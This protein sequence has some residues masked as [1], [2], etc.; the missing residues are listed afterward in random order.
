MWEI[1][2]F[3]EWAEISSLLTDSTETGKESPSQLMYKY[4]K[5]ND[6]MRCA[7]VFFQDHLLWTEHIYSLWTKK[8]VLSS[9]GDKSFVVRLVHYDHSYY[10]C[11]V[12]F[13]GSC[14]WTTAL[15]QRNHLTLSLPLF[16]SSH[17]VH[18]ARVLDGKPLGLLVQP[19]KAVV[20]S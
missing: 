18:R 1:W 3:Q 7:G 15:G 4:S 8:L 6:Q 17:D 2:Y 10:Y 16:Y 11:F 19:H 12:K 5:V 13:P 14:L 9:A 20:S